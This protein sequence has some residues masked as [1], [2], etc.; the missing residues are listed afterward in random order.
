MDGRVM[1]GSD[2]LWQNRGATFDELAAVMRATQPGVEPERFEWDAEEWRK[3][4]PGVYES[5]DLT[6]RR[7]TTLSESHPDWVTYRGNE[8]LDTNDTLGWAKHDAKRFRPKPLLGKQA[9]LAVIKDKIERH[10]KT[11]HYLLEEMAGRAKKL[12]EHDAARAAL[13]AELEAAGGEPPGVGDALFA[14]LRSL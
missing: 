3:V 2:P 5:E 7:D 8:R 6:I 10:G 12:A 1:T 14:Y 11:R 9:K 13:E 4:G